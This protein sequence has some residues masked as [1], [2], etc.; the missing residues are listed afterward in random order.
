MY[1]K[2]KK[3]CDARGISIYKFERD[4][5]LANGS[6]SK[7]RAVT[8]SLASAKMVADYFGISVDMLIAG[9]DLSKGEK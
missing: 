6:V 1:D 2:V 7:W 4:V 5:G 9:V 3:L 8:P